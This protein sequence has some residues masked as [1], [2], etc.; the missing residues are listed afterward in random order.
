MGCSGFGKGIYAI[1]QN[2]CYNY[3]NETTTL[4]SW[5]H[6]DTGYN[7]AHHSTTDLVGWVFKE[8]DT[9]RVDVD[10]YN[11]LVS[12]TL[13]NDGIL[14]EEQIYEMPIKLDSGPVYPFVS[15]AN[16]G[17]RVAIIPA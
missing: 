16:K 8:G 6:H 2:N 3:S 11:S 7:Q 5:N 14:E 1:D 13:S 15:I 17:C 9:V 12:F 10:Y 4:A